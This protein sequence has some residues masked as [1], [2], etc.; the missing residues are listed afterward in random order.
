LLSPTRHLI[1]AFFLPETRNS[2]SLE[3]F[4]QNN[5]NLLDFGQTLQGLKLFDLILGGAV[6]GRPGIP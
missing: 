5:S 2:F 3:N 6:V 1:Q 4:D